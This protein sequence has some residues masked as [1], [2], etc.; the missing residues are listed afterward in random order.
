[1]RN[2]PFPFPGE[3]ETTNGFGGIVGGLGGG[4]EVGV[5]EVVV[6][7]NVRLSSTSYDYLISTPYCI[8]QFNLYSSLR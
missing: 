3:G 6:W 7:R 1:M 4:V 5:E 2:N 8:F